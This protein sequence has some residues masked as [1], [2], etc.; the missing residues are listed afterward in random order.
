MAISYATRLKLLKVWNMP[1]V[2]AS[3]A[4]RPL[5]ARDGSVYFIRRLAKSGASK[6]VYV[7]DRFREALGWNEST[8]LMLWLQGNVLCVQEID[9]PRTVTRL[10]P[11]PPRGERPDTVPEDEEA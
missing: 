4:V 7:P 6:A 10:I 5:I 1:K 3:K 8:A 11:I 2:E 9:P